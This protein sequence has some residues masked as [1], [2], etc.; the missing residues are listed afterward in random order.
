MMLKR[1]AER[2]FRIALISAGSPMAEP[3][4]ALAANGFCWLFH[5]D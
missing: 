2:I 4:E 3:P 5:T 1:K